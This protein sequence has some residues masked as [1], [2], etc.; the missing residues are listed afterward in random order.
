MQRR[1]FIKFAGVGVGSALFPAAATAAASAAEVAPSPS[2]VQ[3]VD[4]SQQ[5]NTWNSYLL[6]YQVDLPEQG[7]MA[8]LWLPLPDS[9][10]INHQLSQGSVWRGNATIAGFHTLA[11]TDSPVFH[12]EWRGCGPRSVTVSSVVKT[13]DRFTDL[14]EYSGSAKEAIPAEI[15]RFLKPT[16]H[17]PLDG[18][19]RKTALSI[20][21]TA[22]AQS[23][24][25]KARAIYDWVVDNAHRDPAIRGCGRGDIKSMLETGYLGGKCADL[26][27]LFVGL[28]RA[29]GIPARDRYGIRVDESTTFKSLGKLG[30]ITKAQ[31]CRA[32]FYLAGL[33]WVPVD[34]A[35]V[36]KAVLEENLPLDDTRIV[37]LREKLFGAW[38][39]NWVA[40]NHAEE[41][42]LARDSVAGRLPFFMY[43]HAEIGG[44]QQDSLEPARFVY[45]IV[46]AELVGTGAQL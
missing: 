34:P 19:V 15:K 16:P 33:G 42:V 6:T 24:K 32:E 21:K 1:D 46:S 23:P 37:A 25:K 20:I 28:T 7:K 30:N 13:T 18:I 44:Q 22:N 38:E 10:D 41:V 17:I 2:P 5:K 27:A 26:N 9:A 40:F 45:S 3:P 31:L 39:M 36:R 14:C 8:R 35:D 11:G 43:P 12:A 29:V 4:L